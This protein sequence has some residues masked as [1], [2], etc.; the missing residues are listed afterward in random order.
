MRHRRGLLDSPFQRD[1]LFL[2]ASFFPDFLI[3][4]FLLEEDLHRGLFGSRT[5][6]NFWSPRTASFGGVY[7]LPLWRSFAKAACRSPG[8]KT[9]ILVPMIESSP[10][11][12]I[13]RSGPPGKR[14]REGH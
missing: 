4:E 2:P 13:H 1:L 14:L 12:S 9:Y 7:I 10:S 5:F 11:G 8:F 6:L 3:R